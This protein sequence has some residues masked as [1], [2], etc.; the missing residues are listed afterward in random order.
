MIG[1]VHGRQIEK[2]STKIETS[3]AALKTKFGEL[4]KAN[5]SGNQNQC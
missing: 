1:H 5:N 4:T 2:F 3:F